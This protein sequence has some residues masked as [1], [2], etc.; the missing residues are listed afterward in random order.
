MNKLTFIQSLLGQCL[1]VGDEHI[2]TCPFCKHNKK[3]LSINFSKG[4][5]KCWICDKAGRS[6]KTLV[7]QV[8]SAH[9]IREW[10]RITDSVDLSEIGD[11]NL[12][13]LFKKE[14][15]VKQIVTLPDGFVSL[16]TRKK[17][18]GSRKAMAYLK[19]RRISFSDLLT[20][21]VGI[22]TKG[23]HAGRIIVPSFDLNGDLNYFIGRAYD[24]AWPRYM[25]AGQPKKEIVFNELSLDFSKEIT[26][27]EGV[28]D[29]I[30]A[31]ENSVPLLGS[32]L[33]EMDLLFKRL[34]ENNTTVYMALDHDARKKQDKIVELLLHYGLTVYVVN[35]FG[36]PDV[37]EMTKE[38]FVK[39]KQ[40]A[41]LSD[42]WSLFASAMANG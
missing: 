26:I 17:V 9:H 30:V 7:R 27:V 33:R 29:A 12:E 25:N 14:E 15:K 40:E 10:A 34:V 19:K 13:N 42:S 1:V 38:Q 28:F 4:K 32:T 5:W 39:R 31:G 16:A 23:T 2:Y 8:G 11:I 20:W 18:R 6:I 21:K 24:G 35:T 37:G 3:K 22:C 41:T 36:F